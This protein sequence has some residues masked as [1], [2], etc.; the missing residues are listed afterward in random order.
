MFTLPRFIFGKYVTESVQLW[1]SNIAII[2]WSLFLIAMV[3]TQGPIPHWKNAIIGV[4]AAPLFTIGVSFI[5]DIVLL[6]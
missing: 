6:K 5:D 4:S 2:M 1:Y 3:V